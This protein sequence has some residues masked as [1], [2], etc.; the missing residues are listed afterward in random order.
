MC[1]K[2]SAST[3]VSNHWETQI[4]FKSSINDRFSSFSKLAEHDGFMHEQ[5]EENKDLEKQ[6]YQNYCSCYHLI[7]CRILFRF[8]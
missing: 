4:L 5:E 8:I 1:S 7:I 2:R 6:K 3:G